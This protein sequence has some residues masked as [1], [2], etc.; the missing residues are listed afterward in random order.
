M[1]L[2]DSKVILLDGTIGLK[3]AKERVLGVLIRL[4][5]LLQEF[6]IGLLLQIFDI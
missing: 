6:L 3:L 2:R 1:L 4:N 5:A